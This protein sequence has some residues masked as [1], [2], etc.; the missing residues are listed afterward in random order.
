MIAFASTDVFSQS[1]GQSSAFQRLGFGVRAKAMGS[2][3]V[4]V[5]SDASSAFWNPAGIA[6]VRNIQQESS[7]ARLPLKRNQLAFVISRGFD[8]KFA[9]ALGVVSHGVHEIDGRDQTGQSIGEFSTRESAFLSTFA[10]RLGSSSFGVSAKYLRSSLISTSGNGFGLDL[11]LQHRFNQFALGVTVRD[12]LG[13]ISWNESTE[14]IPLSVQGGI[15]FRP[16]KLPLVLSSDLY[17]VQN[18]DPL[19]RIGAEYF[20]IDYFGLRAGFDSKNVSLGGMIHLPGDPMLAVFNFA[21][22]RDVVTESYFLD[23][24]IL[25][26]L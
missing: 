24:S 18:Q 17:W 26:V 15:A 10:Y 13:S 23:L 21:V 20:L 14:N 25:F 3:Y 7:V 5:A 22:L 6:F 2:A 19:I 11:G 8:R 1:G 12:L 16:D 4:A 9:L